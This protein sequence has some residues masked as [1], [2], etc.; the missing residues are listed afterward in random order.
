[1]VLN[2]ISDTNN[3]Y[4]Y[5]DPDNSDMKRLVILLLFILP[6]LFS[7][8]PKEL[9]V[10]VE[11]VSVNPTSKELTIGETLQLSATVSPS[12]ATRKEVTWSSS[13]SSVASVNASGLVTALSEGTTTVTASA[14]GK[15]GACT[16]SVVKG[17]VAVSEV[18]LGKTEVTLYE[19]EEETLTATVLPD[20]ATDKTITWSTSDKSIVTVESGKVK[21]V[22]NGEA[23]I[24]AQA[25][26]KTAEVKVVVLA[27]ISGLSLDKD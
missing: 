9:E 2:W 22:K 6:F 12:E 4:L 3:R 19:G 26:D 27:P 17:F 18:R 8:T 13:N 15:K 5:Y 20:D 23:T 1:M 16:V 7:C 10:R 24:T 11:S 25:G 14:D 21:A